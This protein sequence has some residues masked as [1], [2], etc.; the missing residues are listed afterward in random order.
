MLLNCDLTLLQPKNPSGKLLRKE[1]RE[2]A[3]AEVGDRD[4]RESKM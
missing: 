3:K 2:R 4:V 1:L